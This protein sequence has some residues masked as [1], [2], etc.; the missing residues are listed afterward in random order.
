M[1]LA[2]IAGVAITTAV[3]TGALLVGDSMRES[4]RRLTLD[5]L[6]NI[7]QV[8]LNDRFFDVALV[9]RI[10]EQPD[11]S[12]H[13]ETGSVGRSI[14][15]RGS[16]KNP[17]SGRRASGVDLLGVEE[18][19]LQL[20]PDFGS[21]ANFVLEKQLDQIFPSVVINAPLQRELGVEV[22]DDVLVSF[23][24]SSDVPRVS[25]LGRREDADLLDTLRLTVAGVIPAR[26]PGRFGLR[27]QQTRPLNAFVDLALLQRRLDRPDQINALLLPVSQSREIHAALDAALERVLEVGDLG[28]EITKQ[29]SYLT[30]ESREL[31][32]RPGIASAID[33]LAADAEADSWPVLTYLANQIESPGHTLPY[34]TV[35][36]LS[37]PAPS[38]LG[39]FRYSDETSPT[40][41][42]PD[43]IVLNTWAAEDL[44]VDVGDEIRMSYFLVG[45][46]DELVTE[47][48]TFQV[49]AIVEL[50][51][52]AADSTLTPDVP[53]VTGADDMASWDPPFPVDLD[54]VRP[55]DEEYWD[56]YGATPKAFVD[57]NVGQE[58]WKSRYG[59]ITSVRLLPRDSAK[60]DELEQVLRRDLPTD[61]S[62]NAA[63]F[64][65]LPVRQQGLDAASGTADFA[66]LFSG[67]SLFLIVAAVLLV[68]LLFTLLVEQRGREAGLLLALG[69]QPRQLQ[70]KMML[71]GGLLATIGAAGGAILALFYARLVLRGLET[72]WA[73]VVESTFL[74]I[75]VRPVTILMGALISVVLVLAAILKA[76]RRISR[77]PARR[78][79]AG[80]VELATKTSG[81]TRRPLIVTA[82]SLALALGL[83]VTS[84]TAAQDSSPALFFGIGAALVA[85]GIAGFS[86]WCRR[87][88]RTETRFCRTSMLQIAA[89][90]SARHSGRS[91]LSVALVASASFVLVSVTA[92]RKNPLAGAL[93]LHSGIGGLTL[94]AESDISLPVQLTTYLEQLG[95]GLVADD[96]SQQ[97]PE[98]PPEVLSLRLLRGEDVSCLNLYQPEKPRILGVPEDFVARDAFRFRS[99]LEEVDNPWT[100]LQTTFED[101]AI[102]AV[103]DYNSVLWILH[104]G[105]GKDLVMHDDSGTEIHLRIVGLLDASIFQSE[106]LISEDNF[107]E[108]FPGQA[109]YGYFLASPPNSELSSSIDHLEELLTPFGFDAG[110]SS[111]RLASYQAVENMYLATFEALGGLGLILGTLGLA[112]V[113]LRNVIERQGELATL[114][115]FGYRKARIASMVV[116][117]NAFLLAV[118]L[119]IGAI[120]GI[121]AVAPHLITGHIT[122]PWRSLAA[123]LTT[124]FGV[125][126][127]ASIGAVL[128][129]LRI[130]L[131]PALKAE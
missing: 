105:L 72:W 98:P 9:D 114:R 29:D 68:V 119:L 82:L 13:L 57:I 103:G 86:L 88:G 97:S 42:T 21:T 1:N 76:V 127:L 38:S 89:R 90:N 78:L 106:L 131:L 10:L 53:G 113:L 52:L 71:E 37:L 99:S 61:L 92:N 120:S 108:H 40:V 46:K 118:G 93:D 49:T 14:L 104:L 31:V 70:R 3:V 33:R 107:I 8:L 55:Q 51:G 116:A 101:G 69:Y 83:F 26:G 22:G 110:S 34:S 36:A 79:L 91:L 75:H 5:R 45:A 66:G 94:V 73:P 129:S 39:L 12:S 95:T 67:F 47:S 19:F 2:V 124:V 48:R 126:L 64:S 102:P 115:A 125:G 17:S 74:E 77:V 50:A 63:G 128:T 87:S 41:L 58:L 16:I 11:V 28:L 30:I 100:L 54:L 24:R 62:P 4:L 96:H 7:D 18:E 15:L 85:A 43:Q 6:G 32:I 27:P 35:T 59:Q 122:V 109:G 25:L 44:D 112:V 111:E 56:L 23:G 60:L 121:V 130:P 20:F 123:I 65:W 84:I 80:E 117:E 81:Q